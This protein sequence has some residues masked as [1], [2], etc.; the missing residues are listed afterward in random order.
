[1]FGLGTV[2]M[3]GVGLGLVTTVFTVADATMFR[4]WRVPD[5]ETL[6]YV[7]STA[8][9]ATDFAGVSVPEHRYLREHSRSFRQLALTVRGGRVRLFYDAEAYDRVGSMTVSANYFD[10]LGVP[11]IAG[12]SFLPGEDTTAAPSNL[13]IISERLWTERFN[14]DPATIGRTVRLDSSRAYTVVGVVSGK[15]LDGSTGPKSDAFP[16]GCRIHAP[17][18]SARHTRP[19]C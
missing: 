9:P 17:P 2:V 8:A 1:M 16:F 7:R 11:I 15:F 4:P 19:S 10:L 13:I 6:F 18:V 12:R 3:L 5:P 14:R